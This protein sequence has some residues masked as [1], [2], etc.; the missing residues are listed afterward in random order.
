MLET[1]Y[2]KKYEIVIGMN[3]KERCKKIGF[4]GKIVKFNESTYI[5]RLKKYDFMVGNKSVRE[6]FI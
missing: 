2:Y 1:S 3:F 6:F 5:V 4:W